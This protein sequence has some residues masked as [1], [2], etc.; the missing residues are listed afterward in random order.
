MKKKLLLTG[1]TGFLGSNLLRRFV[2]D[3]R[4]EVVLLK[5]SFSNAARIK[6]LIGSF[7]AYDVDSV[8]FEKVFDENEISV[9]VHC[10]TNYGRRFVPASELIDANLIYPLRLLQLGQERGRPIFINTDTILDKRINAYSLSK[11][12]FFDWFEFFSQK[13]V[14]VN[15]ALEHFFGPADDPSKFVTRIVLDLLREVDALDLTLGEQKRD[16]IYIDDVVEAFLAIIDHSQTLKEGLYRFEVGS[17]QNTSIREFVE[18]VKSLT[19]NSKTRLNFG[20]LEYRENEVMESR[21]DLRALRALGWTP[22]TSV[23]AGLSRTI[24]AERSAFRE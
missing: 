19:G 12:H 5:R 2:A 21:V 6:D 24:A 9:I 22:K 20:A 8:P 3:G 18:L 17:G 11:K 7:R 10:A 13:S 15:V 16:F 1:G 4:Y 23:Q 14:C